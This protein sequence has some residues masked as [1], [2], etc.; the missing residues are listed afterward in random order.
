MR[1][2][3]YT[4]AHALALLAPALP[5]G[6]IIQQRPP[7]IE[8]R[9]MNLNVLSGGLATVAGT[10]GEAG[11]GA[12][13]TLQ[14]KIGGRWRTRASALAGAH[15][16]FFLAF[17]ARSLGSA[18]VRLR[19]SADGAIS[20]FPPAGCIGACAPS[21]QLAST[22]RRA[23]IRPLGT[24]NVYRAVIA[25]WYASGGTTACGIDLTPQTL[26]VANRT[27]PCGT[28]V[29]LHYGTRTIRV[30]VIDRGPFVEGREYDLTEATKDALDFP[31]LGV[32]WSTY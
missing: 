26:G 24:L 4:L 29:T 6:E 17:R 2:I 5:P 13:I 15:G 7:Q 23:Q 22:R 18:P 1:T 16:R 19:S 32:V 14:A 25:S 28:L 10:L 8:V 31:S 12:S 9:S 30:P 27:L 3:T 20:A 11:A 21:A